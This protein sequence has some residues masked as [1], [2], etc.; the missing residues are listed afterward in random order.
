[1]TLNPGTTYFWR[2]VGKTMAD[3]TANGPL[4]SFTTSGSAPAPTPTPSPTP[5]PTPGQ[6]SPN[7][8]RVPPATQITDSTGAVWTRAANG[9]ILRN[10]VQ[11]QGGVGSE[12]LYCNHI[13]Y[14]FGTDAQ[15]Y[16]WSNGWIGQG[17][18]DPCGGATPT[19]TPTPTPTA[20]PTPT[21]V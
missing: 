6:E 18:V 3:K 16:R 12:I 20:T 11:A 10:G 14:V 4:W 1:M 21:P 7:N 17:S 15:W 13:V 8:T 9:A 2:I 19:P 5:T